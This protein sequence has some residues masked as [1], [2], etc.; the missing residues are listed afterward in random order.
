ME[1]PNE[2]L[3]LKMKESGL[4][5]FLLLVCQHWKKIEQLFLSDAKMLD[6]SDP[7]WMQIFYGNMSE[8]EYL[9]TMK[10]ILKK[11]GK[12]IRHLKY[13]N[14][15]YLS[16]GHIFPFDNVMRACSRIENIVWL[17]N[18]SPMDVSKMVSKCK[19]IVE[20][21]C[22]V[23][24][25]SNTMDL[26][27]RNNKSLRWLKINAMDRWQKYTGNMSKKIIQELD[28]TFISQNVLDYLSLVSFVSYYEER[29]N[30]NSARGALHDILSIEEDGFEYVVYFV[31]AIPDFVED[32]ITQSRDEQS[33]G[34]I[35]RRSSPTAPYCTSERKA[36]AP[37]SCCTRIAAYQM[38]RVVGEHTFAQP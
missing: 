2:F 25:P 37:P 29:N 9:E 3:P 13:D 8:E 22:D 18:I 32:L 33:W 35:V 30:S 17:H 27:I 19:E 11:Y 6:T 24:L 21:R 4:N 38:Y 7:S 14:N 31:A 20:F 36:R 15:P 28:V 16:I 23:D 5:F 34:V 10:S 1:F 26:L 12:H